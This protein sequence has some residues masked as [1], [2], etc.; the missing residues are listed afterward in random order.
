MN[1]HPNYATIDDGWIDR[2]EY[3]FATQYADLPGGRMH[4]VDEG[5][6]PVLLMVHGTPTWSFLYRHL[7]KGLSPY[8]RCIAPD[9]IGFGLSERPAPYTLRTPDHAHNLQLLV[10]H[11][12]LRDITLVVHDFGGP[13]GLS[14]A[15]DHP[16]N[17]RAFVIAN[18]W[19]WSFPTGTAQHRTLRL[20]D[21]AFGRWLYQRTPFEFGMLMPSVWGDKSRLTPAVRK[22]YAGA[23][24]TPSSR[25]PLFRFAQET[26][27]R[28]AWYDE[29]WAR[30]ERIADKPA[31][32]AWGR[33]DPIFGA[34]LGRWKSLFPHA[35]TV[36][37]RDVGHFVPD[38]R[39]PELAPVVKEWLHM[40]PHS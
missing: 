19:L 20:L 2:A 35:E 39:G 4:Y 13:I 11:L 25:Q 10:D 17:V 26:L 31:L 8:F 23:F 21:S 29:L 28:A 40:L 30:R 3:P 14:Y 32:L 22:Q 33:K 38:E 12:G 5:D 7:I 34:E 6:G 37:Y 15:I 9:N 1:T 24:P 16:A 18:T 27:Q 36:E